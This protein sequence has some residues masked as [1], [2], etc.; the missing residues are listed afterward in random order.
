MAKFAIEDLKAKR[1]GVLYNVRDPYST[2]LRD[3][4]IAYAKGHGAEILADLS[5]SSGDPDFR[6]QLTRFVRL[7]PDVIYA[8]GYYS[9]I[10]PICRQARSMRLTMPILG[11]DG[12]D[13]AKTLELAGDSANGCYFTNHYSA[14]DTRPEVQSFISAFK[15]RYNRVPDALS[16]LGYDG[17]RIMADAI[18]RAKS[19]DGK[20]VRDALA[21]TKDFPAASGITTIDANRNAQKP[22]VILQIKDRQ[23]RFHKAI[24]LD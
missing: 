11:S 15:A 4:F 12:W 6:G 5:Y 10:G 1:I 9:E 16:I 13:S 2:G 18:T 3:S 7:K 8:P 19:T 22:I 17:M 21:A 24:A 14:E 20:A 23:F